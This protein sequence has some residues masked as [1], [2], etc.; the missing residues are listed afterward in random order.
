M[1]PAWKTKSLLRL[2][3]ILRLKSP[4][5]ESGQGNQLEGQKM[6]ETLALTRSEVPSTLLLPSV[7]SQ[8]QVP[9]MILNLFFS[10]FLIASQRHY[11]IT[12]WTSVD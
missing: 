9:A 8:V 6:L 2:Q 10:M 7:P 1:R 11:V 4:V 12:S 5:I 3:Q